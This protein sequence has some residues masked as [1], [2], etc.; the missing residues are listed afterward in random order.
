MKT[1][2][3][4]L[5]RRKPISMSFVIFRDNTERF[6]RKLNNY[7]KMTKLTYFRYSVYQGSL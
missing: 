1:V 7:L 5:G 3:S 6:K 4:L 2:I